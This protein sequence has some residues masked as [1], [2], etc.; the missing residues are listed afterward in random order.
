M[1]KLAVI[2]L[3]ALMAVF[4]LSGCAKA[5]EKL[6]EQ[7]MEKVIEE[8]AEGEGENVDVDIG[9]EEVKITTDEGDEI[10]IGG[11]DIPDDWPSVVPVHPDIDIQTSFKSTSDGKNNFSI[12]AMYG[13][14]G[15]DLFNWYKSELS[16]WNV[17]SEFS[18]NDDSGKSYSLNVEN[19]TYQVS[20]LIVESD[21]DQEVMLILNATEM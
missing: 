10:N 14:S 3:V 1:K 16:G 17:V 4:A 18:G 15:E 12:S 20:V 7:V 21:D 19:G 5:G 11:A 2:L 8:A 6:A 9:D 13:G